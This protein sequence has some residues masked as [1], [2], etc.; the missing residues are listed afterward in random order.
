M[1]NDD[2]TQLF[3]EIFS[4]HGGKNQHSLT[5][6][7]S[8]FFNV[9]LAKE[10]DLF[11]EEETNKNNKGNGFYDRKLSSSLGN[12]DISVPRDRDGK[13]RS[14][15]LPEKWQKYDDSYQN[16]ILNLILNAYAPNKIKNILSNMNLPYSQ[17]QVDEIKDELLEKSATFFSREL[18]ENIVSLYIDAYQCPVKQE[19]T[20]KVVKANI[21]VAMGVDFEGITNIYG[22][23]TIFGNE[24]KEDW[25]SNL[26]T[27][28]GRGLKRPLVVVSDDLAGLTG[29]I[30]T[31][32]PNSDH[33]LCWTHCKRTITRNLNKEDARVCKD[34][35]DKAK[36][37][38]FEEASEI[39]KDHFISL[40]KK[41]PNFISHH[42]KRVKNYF[43]FLKYPK[44]VQSTIYT[45]NKAESFN[46]MLEVLRVN[47]GGHFQSQN[48][49]A[50]AVYVT[51]EK[52]IRKKWKKGNQKIK[53]VHYELKQIFNH[54]FKD[55][56]HNL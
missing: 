4:K 6:I 37:F 32:F 53:G 21:Y 19:K 36:H 39:L 8:R 2:L 11:L 48:T 17:E 51:I 25:M 40:E 12:L 29:A 24:S 28:I 22:F 34:L 13:L 14:F 16:F 33:Q 10:R 42:Q 27:L 44:D 31:L 46:S 20:K 18:P 55:Q 9:L 35:L 50:I 56:G 26:N 47:S 41:Y 30:E 7:A 52:L 43:A 15:F 49:I 38:D 54:K 1:K 23:W 5:D 3:E 45:T